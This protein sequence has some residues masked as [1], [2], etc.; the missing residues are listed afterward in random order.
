MFSD[1][2]VMLETNSSI[3][4]PFSDVILELSAGAVL[5]RSLGHGWL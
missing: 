2:D 3:K 1:I 4:M 5:G